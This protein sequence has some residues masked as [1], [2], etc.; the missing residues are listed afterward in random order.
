MATMDV[1]GLLKQDLPF[2]R[3]SVCPESDVLRVWAAPGRRICSSLLLWG[4]GHSGECIEHCKRVYNP[5]TDKVSQG[6]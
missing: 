1:K 2:Y 4:R 3:F 6:L 5:Q